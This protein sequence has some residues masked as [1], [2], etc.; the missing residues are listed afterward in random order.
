M[1]I[2]L[3][4]AISVPNIQRVA[5]VRPPRLYDGIAICDFEARSGGATPRI[6][7]IEVNVRNGAADGRCDVL[8][9]K[10][11]PASFDDDIEVAPSSREVTGAADAV[12]AAYRGGANKAAALRAVETYL[13]SA[14]IVTLA[15]T[16]S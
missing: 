2:V 3:T 13:L 14:G 12:E 1:S 5:L 9:I 16:V 15:G 6:K 11:A 7:R 10:A 8:R 4:S